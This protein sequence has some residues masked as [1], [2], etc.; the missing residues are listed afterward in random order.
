MKKRNSNG[1][2]VKEFVRNRKQL[3]TP[4][5]SSKYLAKA[6][7]KQVVG[8]N[9]VELGA[10]AGPVTKAILNELKEEA[11]RLTAFEN[12][13]RLLEHLIQIEDSRLTIIGESAENFQDYIQDFDCIVSGLPLTSMPKNVVHSILNASKEA[14][15]YIQYKYFPE[16]DLLKQYFS[17]VKSRVV[18]R[19]IPPLTI[20]YICE[21]H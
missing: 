10:G 2:F 8:Y 18:F 12:N 9:I 21:N 16:G 15:R 4:F 11:V 17:S 3:G 19:N 5:Q 6:V 20:V 1:D 7:A 14:Q 13:P